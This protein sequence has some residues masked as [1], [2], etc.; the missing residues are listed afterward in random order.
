MR[1][2]FK[3]VPAIKTLA[4]TLS[5]WTMCIAPVAQG[6]EAARNKQLINQ[7]LKESGLTTQKM[8]IGQFWGKVRHIYP[9]VLQKQLDPWMSIHKNEPMPSIEASSFKDAD[10]NEQVRIVL[11]AGAETG[12]LTFTGDDEKPLKVNGVTLSRAELADYNKFEQLAAKI[13]NQD[14]MLKKSLK[15]GAKNSSA[16]SSKSV[17]TE[18]RFLKGKDIAKLPLRQQMDYFL[19]M[20]T[21]VQAADRVL[22]VNKG[23]KGASFD[24][25]TSDSA[26][27]SLWQILLGANAVA[28]V[29]Q[30][31]I[32]SGWV[33]SYYQGS[34]ARPEQGQASLLRQVE[35]LPFSATVKSKVTSCA[36]GGGLPCNP[37]LFGFSD[38]SGSPICITSNLAS[39]T[40][41]CNEKVPLPQ[42]RERIIQSIVAARGNDGSLCKVKD[43]NTVSQVCADKLEKYTDNLQAH[44]LNAAQFC[45]KGG[46]SSIE[47]RAE[48]ERKA[49]TDIKKDQ[50]EA[51][52]NLKDRF[53]DLK[54]E[55]S[56]PATP[57]QPCSVR[58]PGSHE[59]DGGTCLCEDGKPPRPPAP[60][61]TSGGKAGKALPPPPVPGESGAVAA[62]QESDGQLV[63]EPVVI[64]DSGDVTNT[65]L[66]P[67]K[68]VKEDTCGFL[69]KYKGILIAVGVGLVGLG[70]F[71]WLTKKKTKKSTPVYTP[72]A[73]PPLPDP[74]VS[75]TTVPT[76][77]PVPQNPCPAPNTV[78]NGVCT[79]PIFV[80]PDPPVVTPPSTEGG[81]GTGP[82]GGAIR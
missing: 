48:W 6:A 22:E 74:T 35:E 5:M 24:Y 12:T 42:D 16:K 50:K 51:C 54:V 1:W 43:D 19:K 39:A 67:G 29:E 26:V 20:R 36:K 11:K 18:K 40:K 4:A 47:S 58:I 14:P 44:Y 60:K 72:P 45:T 79:A 28:K 70:L 38:N 81:T 3:P 61:P 23:S 71:W 68:T 82:T 34:C 56:G 76:V 30:A 69:C 64:G 57:A 37:L 78:I 7:Y 65:D 63:C 10:N 8:T 53:F 25:S 13:G 59:G 52:D 75:P 32:A 17:V 9:S 77:D 2:K 41:Q 46:V 62:P 21:A 33:A 15:E 80:P 73:P 66:P 55:V 31:C 49:R 27:A